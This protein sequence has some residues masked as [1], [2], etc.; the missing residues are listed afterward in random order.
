MFSSNRKCQYCG[1]EINRDAFVCQFCGRAQPPR[2]A[3]T[4]TQ[5]QQRQLP[6]KTRLVLIAAGAW[7]LLSMG[8][9][10]WKSVPSTFQERP[11]AKL[12]V[13]GK[14][15]P[16]GLELVNHEKESLSGCV[17]TLQNDWRAM[18]QTFKAGEIR[19]VPWS[20]FRSRG[21][22]DMPTIEGERARYAAVN[23]DSHRD[24][25]RGA[26]LALR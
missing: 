24:T 15:G 14:R 22:G 5:T 13:Y 17:I 4:S 19:L 25:R 18:I 1:Q 6:L 10:W 3:K 9:N 20:D 12:E 11:K 7:V 26:A 2:P 21:G 8:V 16:R 23:C